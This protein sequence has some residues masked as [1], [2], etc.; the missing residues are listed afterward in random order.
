MVIHRDEA[1]G[2]TEEFVAVAVLGRIAIL[3]MEA[4]APVHVRELV[5]E[6][7]GDLAVPVVHFAPRALPVEFK[8]ELS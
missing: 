5:H 6:T 1:V 3:T 2:Q 4:A 8:V 7:V